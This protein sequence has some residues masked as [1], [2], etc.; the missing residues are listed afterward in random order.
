MVMPMM[1]MGMMQHSTP[2]G[3]PM[4]VSDAPGTKM[5]EV[6]FIMPSTGGT[7]ALDLAITVGGE[8]LTT[9]VNPEVIE[10]EFKRLLNL[11]DQRDGETR[12]FIALMDPMDPEVGENDLVLGVYYRE[13]MMS[14]PQLSGLS[15]AAEPWMPSMSHGSPNNVDPTETSAGSYQGVVNFSMTG[16][17]EIRL[18]ITDA[19]GETVVQDAVFEFLFQ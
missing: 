6:T 11:V 12:V 4:N 13:N 14:F 7:W 18:D 10:P 1:D 16:D 2:Y 8:E 5:S 17:W 15:I 9:T 3:M 19:N